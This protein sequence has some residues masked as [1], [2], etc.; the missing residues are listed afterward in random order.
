MRILVASMPADGH[1][2]PLTGIAAHL[3]TRGH[4]VRWYA[5]PE[6][7]R[8]LH[9]LGMTYLP[10]RRATEITGASLNDVPERTGLKGPSLISFDLEQFFVANVDNHFRDIVDIR[11]EFPFDV[12]FCDGAMYV[13]KLSPTSSAYPCLR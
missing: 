4:D 2:N 1:F 7:G 8:K 5:G 11:A 12:F 10:Y 9:A 6:Y 3:S 13:E